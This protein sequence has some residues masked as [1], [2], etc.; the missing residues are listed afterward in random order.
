LFLHH[1]GYRVQRVHIRETVSFHFLKELID[2]RRVVAV[3]LQFH[4]SIV[5]NVYEQIGCSR[6]L[7]RVRAAQAV[8]EI[9]PVAMQPHTPCKSGLLQLQRYAP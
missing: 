3:Q 1:K 7:R 6:S 9:A 8:P 4:G 2:F 5:I